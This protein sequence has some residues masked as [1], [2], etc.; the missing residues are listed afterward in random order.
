MWVLSSSVLTVKN[1]QQLKVWTIR[2]GT[3]GSRRLRETDRFWAAVDKHYGH[4]RYG[5]PDTDEYYHPG[6]VASFGAIRV[7]DHEVLTYTAVDRTDEHRLAELYTQQIPI[8]VLM[9][10]G[11]GQEPR[12]VVIF[13]PGEPQLTDHELTR[14]LDKQCQIC[15][16]EV[17][18]EVDKNSALTRIQT[19]Y[20][21]WPWMTKTVFLQSQVMDALYL[22]SVRTAAGVQQHLTRHF[23]DICKW[24][25]NY[26][27]QYATFAHVQ[28][29]RKTSAARRAYFA[30]T[31]VIPLKWLVYSA[32]A[33]IL[34]LASTATYEY[35]HLTSH[36]DHAWARV[37]EPIH[38]PTGSPTPMPVVVATGFPELNTTGDEESNNTAHGMLMFGGV[39]KGLLAIPAEWAP[40]IDSESLACGG[41]RGAR[42]CVIKQSRFVMTFV[43]GLVLS[44]F[45]CLMVVA[46][47]CL[48]SHVTRAGLLRATFITFAMYGSVEVLRKMFL[49]VKAEPDR[50][51]RRRMEHTWSKMIKARHEL[52]NPWADHF[53][54]CAHWGAPSDIRLA[55]ACWLRVDRI[56]HNFLTDYGVYTGPHPLVERAVLPM[57]DG[58]AG[59]AALGH[60]QLQW[61][62]ETATD[63]GRARFKRVAAFLRSLIGID[64]MMSTEEWLENTKWSCHKKAMFLQCLRESGGFVEGRDRLRKAFIKVEAGIP[65][66]KKA[67]NERLVQAGT[68]EVNLA[69]GPAVASAQKALKKILDGGVLPVLWAAVPLEQIEA[70]VTSALSLGNT[71]VVATDYTRYDSHQNDDMLAEEIE[72]VRS[73][74]GDVSEEACLE[75]AEQRFTRG[76]LT[77]KD[78]TRI[79]YGYRGARRRSGDV[80][81]SFGNSHNCICAIWSV[82]LRG[83]G[84]DFD[85]FRRVALG[86]DVMVMFNGD[87]AAMMMSTLGAELFDK[88][89]APRDGLDGFDEVGLPAV[90]ERPAD[91][92]ELIFLQRQI[93]VGG[94]LTAPYV[95]MVPQL[96]R[97]L[98]KTFINLTGEQS[99]QYNITLASLQW[100]AVVDMFPGVPWLAACKEYVDT[101]K[102][103]TTTRKAVD[104]DVLRKW[105]R[106]RLYKPTPTQRPL[107][108]EL[109][110]QWLALNNINNAM[111]WQFYFEF[112][113][114]MQHSTLG[115]PVGGDLMEMLAG[116][117]PRDWTHAKDH[118]AASGMEARPA[119]YRQL[120]A[121]SLL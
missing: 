98:I 25:N 102:L 77:T 112:V 21:W 63:A 87:D 105:T 91:I 26:V 61:H 16:H 47:N 115:A 17:R 11:V 58:E 37:P 15:S 59:L 89:L 103:R 92:G 4:Q 13:V 109:Y 53:P 120:R 118:N 22:N 97:V 99:W 49:L 32:I 86:G 96:S 20:W 42:H 57:D 104:D 81:T 80:N 111:G 69:L 54:T 106:E 34:L 114:S 27:P 23:A 31:C 121:L 33:V 71:H 75:L 7:N 82:L 12:Q 116:Q 95:C 94:N 68:V 50:D 65:T 8:A 52:A 64:E 6:R 3:V 85:L 76:V 60:R 41:E 62:A 108:G 55:D 28:M 93:L 38:R 46:R 84:D 9:N 73:V 100:Q 113:D 88:G 5:L 40:D 45:V 24:E 19:Y 1:Y 10:D 78:G 72:F 48:H 44:L 83:C 14:C 56:G 119:D 107:E 74:L 51:E 29:T 43:Y 18:T 117:A 90:V 39:T 67:I 30:P 79:S 36:S 110:E 2:R 66:A 35:Y 101:V 70:F